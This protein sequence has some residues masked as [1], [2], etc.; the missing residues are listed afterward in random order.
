MP[1]AILAAPKAQPG[2]MA[3]AAA[4]VRGLTATMREGA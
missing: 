4:Y 1:Q 3:F 2:R